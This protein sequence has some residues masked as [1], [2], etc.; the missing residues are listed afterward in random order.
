V[1]R[2]IFAFGIAP[3]HRMSKAC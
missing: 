1:A 3:R 2:Q